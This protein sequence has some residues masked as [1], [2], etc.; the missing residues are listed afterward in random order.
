MERDPGRGRERPRPDRPRLRQLQGRGRAPDADHRRLATSAGGRRTSRT[1]PRPTASR[2]ATR[3]CARPRSSTAGPRTPS[4]WSPTGCWS[5]SP[6]GSASAAPS[7]NGEWDK[8]FEAYAKD[9]PEA[10]AQL[11]AMQRREL[12]EGWDAD[13]PSFDADEKGTATRKASNKVENAVAAKV[14]WLLPGAADLTGSNSVGLRRARSLR[15]REP[16]RPPVPLRHPRA[17]VGGDLAT[18]CRCR[19]C[20]RSGPPTSPSRDYARPAIRLSL[21]DGAAGDPPLHPRLDRARRGRAD[22]PA[23]RAARLAAGDPGP[24]RDPPRRRQRDRR[25]LEGGDGPPPPAGGAGADPPGRAD[26]RPLQVRLGRGAAPRRLRAGG[27]RRR[28]RR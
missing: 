19:S 2:S 28:R 10:A 27:L 26:A 6:R 25:G 18:G 16:R 17:R 7:S 8:A 24:G 1:P 4:S 21:A 15:A 20:G 13:I 11:E 23:G 12:P 14:P 5:T 3:R 9:E 22:P